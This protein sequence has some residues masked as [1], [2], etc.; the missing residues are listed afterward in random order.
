[1]V[2]SLISLAGGTLTEAK[3]ERY[4]HRL[5]ADMNTSLDTTAKTLARMSKDGYIVKYKEANTA[6]QEESTEWRVGPRGKIEVGNGGVKG[7]VMHVY[8]ENAPKD[9]ANRIHS[10]LGL[11]LVREAG[12]N[13]DE[14]EGRVNAV[15]PD[16]PAPRRRGGRRSS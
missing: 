1:M 2:I 14:D 3:L 9:L 8:G 16:E 15:E 12:E 4:L 6:G 10:S 7:L 11:E 13:R 5:N